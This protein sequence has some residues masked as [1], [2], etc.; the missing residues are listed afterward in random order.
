MKYEEKMSKKS[1]I[2]S[3]IFVLAYSHCAFGSLPTSPFPLDSDNSCKTQL[4]LPSVY[5]E[6]YVNPYE[7]AQPSLYRASDSPSES[8]SS[9]IEE[10]EEEFVSIVDQIITAINNVEKYRTAKEKANILRPLLETEEAFLALKKSHTSKAIQDAIFRYYNILCS[11][12]EAQRRTMPYI[13]V[14]FKG[15][16]HRRC[17]EE[18]IRF[19]EY[20]FITHYNKLCTIQ[21]KIPHIVSSKKIRRTLARLPHIMQEIER[22]DFRNKKKNVRLAEEMGQLF[23]NSNGRLVVPVKRNQSFSVILHYGSVRSRLMGCPNAPSSTE[24][25]V[26]NAVIAVKTLG[27]LFDKGDEEE[28]VHKPIDVLSPGQQGVALFC[29]LSAMNVSHD[30]NYVPLTERA[31]SGDWNIYFRNCTAPQQAAI[32]RDYE[33][34]TVVKKMTARSKSIEPETTKEE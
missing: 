14:A 8:E 32:V 10:E 17:D 5:G 23:D 34:Y 33:Q 21:S 28:P 16:I 26:A 15:V 22:A 11:L 6:H 13:P 19:S 18:E 4:I 2:L 30:P 1:L 29:Y 31:I 25:E 12:D 7:Y 3:S 27:Y 24:E 9:V 20:L